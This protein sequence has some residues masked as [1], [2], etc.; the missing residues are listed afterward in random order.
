MR[1]RTE[2]KQADALF[3]NGH[4][5]KEIGMKL[6]ELRL[7]RGWP[8]AT[9][10]SMTD[11]HIGKIRNM[12]AGKVISLETLSSTLRVFDLDP[13]RFM[14]EHSGTIEPLIPDSVNIAKLNQKSAMKIG[15]CRAEIDRI[16]SKITEF[17]ASTGL[18][19]QPLTEYEVPEALGPTYV[20]TSKV[21]ILAAFGQRVRICRVLRDYT[22]HEL[23]VRSDVPI[24][25]IYV[26]EVG[27]RNPSIETVYRL[28]K[29]L[30]CPVAFLI[31]G[32]HDD[33]NY[34]Q[35]LDFIAYTAE[36]QR[37]IRALEEIKYTFDCLIAVSK[38]ASM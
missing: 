14:R 22:Q 4:H 28:A 15:K 6:A 38:L 24:N 7:A 1:K 33:P 12:D 17:G 8:M 36:T 31:P 27:L 34:L 20:A 5:Y 29:G 3:A 37:K 16:S 21:Q 19:P 11:V 13:S 2:G 30:Q 9:L 23:S 25:S 35:K 18:P 10:A 26:L 32:I